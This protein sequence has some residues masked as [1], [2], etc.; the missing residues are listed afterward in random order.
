MLVSGNYRW[1]PSAALLLDFTFGFA[2]NVCH[3]AR[4]EA[5]HVAQ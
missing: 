5:S 2:K 3:A 1:A 4:R